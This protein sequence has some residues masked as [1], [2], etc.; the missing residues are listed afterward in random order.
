MTDVSKHYFDCSEK[1]SFQLF[2]KFS[3]V[4]HGAQIFRQLVVH[5]RTHVQ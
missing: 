4:G 1:V 3:C 5:M 2:S